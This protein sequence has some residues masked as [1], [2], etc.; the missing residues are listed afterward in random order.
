M[1]EQFSEEFNK[2]MTDLEP[3]LEGSVQV[4]VHG[5]YNDRIDPSK[6]DDWSLNSIRSQVVFPSAYFHGSL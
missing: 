6:L 5:K 4:T 2:V 1:P 3:R